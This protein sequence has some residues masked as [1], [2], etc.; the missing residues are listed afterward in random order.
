M[1]MPNGANAVVPAA[2]LTEYLL[3]EAHPVGGPKARFF[4]A[5]GYTED[6][7]AVLEDGLLLIAEG[8]EVK[9]TKESPF[10]TKYG[11]DG[12]LAT[13]NGRTV[14]ISTVWI[15]EEEGDP[16]RVVTAYPA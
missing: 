6:N 3:S 8:N 10:G 16:P 1:K 11:V 7:A 14:R 13:P 12:D 5:F 2:K 9:K 4:R 15:V